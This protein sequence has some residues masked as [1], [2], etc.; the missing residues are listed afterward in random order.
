MFGG[1]WRGV[2]VLGG[3]LGE[4]WRGVMQPHSRVGGSETLCHGGRVAGADP[5]HST[6]C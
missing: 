4:C 1:Y 2:C 3:Y 6:N 5:G